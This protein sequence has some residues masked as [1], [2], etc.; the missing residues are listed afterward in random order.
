MLPRYARPE[1]AAIWS[2]QNKY[3]LWLQ[4]EILTAKAQADLGLIPHNAAEA[5]QSRGRFDIIRIQQIERETQ[6]E[7]LAFLTNIAEEVGPEARFLHQGLT[8]SDI[9][10]TCLALQLTQAA[11]ILLADLDSLLTVL[12]CR[13]LEHQNTLCIGRT[14]GIHAEPTA[15]GRKGAP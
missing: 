14:H 15:F 10:D 2:E 5:I 13:A 7:M 11:D 1:I 3:Q 4:I 6:H 8:S 12:K 9:L